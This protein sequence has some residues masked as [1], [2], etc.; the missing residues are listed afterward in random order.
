[1]VAMARIPAGRVREKWQPPL[2]PLEEW[3]E[4]KW[5]RLELDCGIRKRDRALREE[6]REAVH[7]YSVL[8]R[9]APRVSAKEMRAAAAKLALA[10]QYW[11]DHLSQVV[12]SEIGRTIGGVDALLGLL[13][14][15]IVAVRM[16]GG[17]L[18]L[19]PDELALLAKRAE[20]FSV[21]YRQH[22]GQRRDV[23]LIEFERRVSMSIEKRCGPKSATR[24]VHRNQSA[25]HSTRASYGGR[26]LTVVQRLQPALP[27]TPESIA[28]CSESELNARLER[29]G[30]HL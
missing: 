13:V 8:I 15:E 11:A 21:H 5:H 10:A 7:L 4:W 29:A 30:N 9:D 6:I 12:L 3:S 16:T 19:E 2:E 27:R 17:D 26:L 28:E 14:P 25:T 20:W 22:G 1:M 18:V 23:A 24:S